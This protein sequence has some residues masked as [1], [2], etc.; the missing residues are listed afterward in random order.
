MTPR[1]EEELID[2]KHAAEMEYEVVLA[3]FARD[4]EREIALLK[5]KF[6]A[7]RQ[8]NQLLELELGNLRSIH[9]ESQKVLEQTQHELNEANRAAN[10]AAAQRDEALTEQ[11]RLRAWGQEWVEKSDKNAVELSKLLTEYATVVEQRDEAQRK[12]EKIC[13][14]L[15]EIE[16]ELRHAEA[17]EARANDGNTERLQALRK[18]I[19]LLA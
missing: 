17:C 12:V 5:S 1:T 2:P 7:G 14:W 8:W 15:E 3:D 19:A 18:L 16:P 9:E 11:K 6:E 13:R 10:E 4:Q